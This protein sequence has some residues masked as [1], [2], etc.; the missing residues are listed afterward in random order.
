VITTGASLV[1]TYIVPNI[2]EEKE[3]KKVE[4]KVFSGT[5]IVFIVVTLGVASSG[6]MGGKQLRS[7]DIITD[8]TNVHMADVKQ[9][10]LRV[11][12]T[13][14]GDEP[15]TVVM[16]INMGSDNICKSNW[17]RQKL[18]ALHHPNVASILGWTEDHA[19]TIYATGG[20]VPVSKQLG[21]ITDC[22]AIARQTCHGL[23]FLHSAEIVHGNLTLDA[24]WIN[25]TSEAIKLCDFTESSR[26]R[27]MKH[28]GCAKDRVYTDRSD[29]W[30]LG[31]V[32]WCLFEGTTITE[33]P[34]FDQVSNDILQSVPQTLVGL[35]QNSFRINPGE[36]PLLDEF[37][38]V[39][40]LQHYTDP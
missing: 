13:R 24:I 35:V 40:E 39:L 5:L 23:E 11:A 37:T 9:G 15:H 1:T 27:Q 22:F 2:E 17:V 28:D 25:T 29:I 19:F 14:F 26:S 7:T 8:L 6:F 3:E 33:V 16:S 4:F 21:N 18:L 20:M 10:Y 32:I 12:E 34:D 31:L 36:R 38:Q 30:D